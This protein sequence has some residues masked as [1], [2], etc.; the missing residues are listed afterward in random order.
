[1][2]LHQSVLPSWPPQNN[3]LMRLRQVCCHPYLLPG[4]EPEVRLRLAAAGD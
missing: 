4:Q 3:I 2:G 1:M